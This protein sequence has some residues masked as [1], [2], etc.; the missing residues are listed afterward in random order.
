MNS[1]ILF[2]QLLVL[3]ALMLTGYIANKKNFIDDNA[4]TKLSSLMVWI[5][6]PMLMISGALGKENHASAKLIGQNLVMVL[7]MYAGL[8]LIGFLYIWICGHKKGKGYM[9][10]MVMLFPNVGFMGVPLVKAIFGTEYIVYV[11]FY[12]LAFNL[13]CYTYG[14]HLASKMG[15]KAT[16]LSIKKLLSPGLIA[17]V[18]TILI[19][20]LQLNV[21]SPIA[22]YVDYMGNTAITVSMLIIG[23]SLARMDLKSAF[24]KAEYYVFLAAKMLIVPIL[25]VFLSK[26]L[27]F[28]P[29]V[30][31]VFQILI[32]MP[33]ASMTCMMAE[34]YGGDGSE[35]TKIITITT[36]CTIV[37][38]PLV[39]LIAA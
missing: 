34:E 8:F 1:F 37:T 12:M 9:Y 10:R 3:C 28:D 14:I 15:E 23:T 21:P 16:K 25:F 31:G 39:I 32:C 4:Y 20:A 6:N 24:L 29:I 30:I 35:C 38:A 13:L 19:F 22:T 11:V 2:Q 33:V 18:F 7:F 5:L 26:L 27:P 36:L 17:S